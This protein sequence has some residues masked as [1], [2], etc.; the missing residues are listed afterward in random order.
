ML[1]SFLQRFPCLDS[2]GLNSG[3]TY[4]DAQTDDA[5]FVLEIIDGACAAG[6]TCLN[7]CQVVEVLE[8]NGVITGAILN[9]K[10]TNKKHQIK[11]TTVVKTTGQWLSSSYPEK[12][13]Y[14]LSKGIHLI[15]PKVLDNEALLLTAKTDGRVFFVIPWYGKTL[16]GTTDTNF[17]G[18]IDD[19]RVKKEDID[20]LLSEVNLALTT[21][22]TEK[23]YSGEIY[24][25]SCFTG[26][27]KKLSF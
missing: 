3:F 24:R 14:R 21:Q 22:W 9:D 11:T 25:A 12:Q 20:Y 1:M 23:R 26:Q 16:L 4:L 10:N 6:A 27:P 19:V 2:T 15:L 7:Y 8:Q 13:W 18:D 17:D 5:R